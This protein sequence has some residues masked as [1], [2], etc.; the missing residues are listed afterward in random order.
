MLNL[1]T[2]GDDA[3]VV[4]K[5]TSSNCLYLVVT[6][7]VADEFLL[8]GYSLYTCVFRKYTINK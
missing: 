6:R 7:S 1:S 3:Y 5:L 2:V 4:G 8:H